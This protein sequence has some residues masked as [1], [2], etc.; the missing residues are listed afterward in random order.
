MI[1]GSFNNCEKGRKAYICCNGPS[2]N[3]VDPN[4]LRGSI[5]FG[6]N[7]GYIKKDLLISYLVS[8]DTL[9][10]QQFASEFLAVPCKARFSASLDNTHH[11]DWTSDKNFLF[12]PEFNKPFY[13]GHSVTITA[14]HLAFWFGCNPVYIVGM[15]HFLPRTNTKTVDGNKF[16]N[17]GEDSNHFDPKYFDSKVKYNYQDLN[18]VE[19]SYK[20]CYSG[21]TAAGRVL[22]NASSTTHLSEDVIPRIEFVAT[23]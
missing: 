20:A 14:L 9:I 10:E 15:D 4:S 13:Q 18:A 17:M 2:L 19:R 6:L 12:Q 8:V 21:Y 1:P 16:I 22:R 5:V 7:R 11:V 23:L 3:D